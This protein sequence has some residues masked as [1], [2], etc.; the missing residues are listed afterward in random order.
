[1]KKL[2]KLFFTF[3]IGIMFVAC[4][5][6]KADYKL[7]GTYTSERLNYYDD[8]TL[9]EKILT[10]IEIT[11]NRNEY[12]V[13]GNKLHEQ[14]EVIRDYVARTQT[15][16]NWEEISNDSWTFTGKLIEIEKSKPVTNI[17]AEEVI[18]FTLENEKGQQMLVSIDKNIN[19]KKL[20]NTPGRDYSN[21]KDIENYD[22]V[23]IIV[24][25]SIKLN[26]SPM[27]AFRME[28]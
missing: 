24:T 25:G 6:P 17:P 4:G 5:K 20:L 28:K 23:D 8:G 11:K 9:G 3:V 13:K 22:T 10:V 14:I 26:L 7:E 18:H 15:Y 21:V 19:V 27:S 1:M 2:V 16:G 12:I